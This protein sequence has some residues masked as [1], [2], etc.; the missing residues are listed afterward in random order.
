MGKTSPIPADKTRERKME[1]PDEIAEDS[2]DSDRT[3]SNDSVGIAYCGSQAEDDDLDADSAMVLPAIGRKQARSDG[4]GYTDG[5]EID[6]ASHAERVVV[7]SPESLPVAQTG[8]YVDI[9]LPKW[10][11]D[12]DS[13]AGM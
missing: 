7:V 13:G 2:I 9:P 4:H 8:D 12:I 10:L 3:V 5:H 11:K 6:S 1:L